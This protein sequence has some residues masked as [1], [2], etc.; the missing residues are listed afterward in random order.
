M[1]FSL[2]RTPLVERHQLLDHLDPE[3][4]CCSLA[5]RK[6]FHSSRKSDILASGD[7]A[8]RQRKVSRCL[9]GLEY[10]WPCKALAAVPAEML[11]GQRTSWSNIDSLQTWASN[12]ST[13]VHSAHIL[14][15]RFTEHSRRRNLTGLY[16]GRI[17][18]SFDRDVCE[19]RYFENENQMSKA[20]FYPC[21]CIYTILVFCAPLSPYLFSSTEAAMYQIIKSFT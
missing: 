3:H 18:L 21:F 6:S 11:L 5:L 2:D 12:D 16:L 13:I 20:V 4:H 15:Q 10:V 17:W 7:I 1:Y 19:G 8:I 14:W 9:T